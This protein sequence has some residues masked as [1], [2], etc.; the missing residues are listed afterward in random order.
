ML[1]RFT[2]IAQGTYTVSLTVSN[3]NGISSKTATITVPGGSNSDDDDRLA[4]A[5]VATGSV[6][7]TQS[8][9]N[10]QGFNEQNNGNTV[11]NF[12]QTSEP[13]QSSNTFEKGIKAPGFEVIFE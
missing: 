2:Y 12:G 5:A 13:I 8:K 3:V 11:A 4:A 7:K 10:T 9:L 6:D 1:T